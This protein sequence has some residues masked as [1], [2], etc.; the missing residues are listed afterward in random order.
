[1]ST[2]FEA[3]ADANWVYVDNKQSAE[4]IWN[5]ATDA[6]VASSDPILQEYAKAYSDAQLVAAVH[7]WASIQCHNGDPCWMYPNS[8]HWGLRGEVRQ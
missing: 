3:W 2:A 7:I 5:A 4:T 6:S 8:N 1:M